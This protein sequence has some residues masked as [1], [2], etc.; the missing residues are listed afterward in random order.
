MD[1]STRKLNEFLQSDMTV[2][3]EFWGSWCP[4]CQRMKKVI[5]KLEK[6]Y[7][8][9]IKIA[10]INIDRNPEVSS[11]Y[12]ISGVPTYIIFKNG[13]IIHRDVGAKSEE[14]LE[15]MIKKMI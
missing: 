14:Q 11:K 9:L 1:F 6:E 15:S 10:S 2:M 4:P 13:E 3:V 12:N 7:D 8:G 5:D